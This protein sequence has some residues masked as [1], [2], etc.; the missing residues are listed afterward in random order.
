MHAWVALKPDI[1]K[2]RAAWNIQT[3]TNISCF[4][5]I[6]LHLCNIETSF[7]SFVPAENR[8]AGH[9]SAY[10]CC[11]KATASD[12][13]RASLCCD[14]TTK[15]Y[16]FLPIIWYRLLSGV[17]CCYN[18]A[19]TI[20]D[21]IWH[22]AEAKFDLVIQLTA[23]PVTLILGCTPAGPL[24]PNIQISMPVT[25]ALQFCFAHE[26]VN[27]RNQRSCM[28]TKVYFLG[29]YACEGAWNL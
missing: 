20:Q 14:E 6:Y 27:I 16:N 1:W 9:R 18:N 15:A 8:F 19:T 28:R 25:L 29:P 11:H 21:R 10:Q 17:S 7:T 2:T 4:W 3:S 13:V 24:T 26:A 22:V 12:D 5:D 23:R